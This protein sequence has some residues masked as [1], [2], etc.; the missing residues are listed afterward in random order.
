M[1]S[2]RATIKMIH[3]H[4]VRLLRV[5]TMAVKTPATAAIAMVIPAILPMS[6]G[7]A[8]VAAS[9]P[10]AGAVVALWVM[11]LS[12]PSPLAALSEATL[13]ILSEIHRAAFL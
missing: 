2:I 1:T 4:Q 9:A 10:A 7:A 5:A 12:V 11:L 13:P 3:C 8:L 6:N